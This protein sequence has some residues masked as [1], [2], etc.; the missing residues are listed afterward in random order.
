MKQED[1]SFLKV[2]IEID[3]QALAVERLYSIDWHL[4]V[5]R[6]IGLTVPG[7]ACFLRVSGSWAHLQA[8]RVS[9][10][11]RTV[12][13]KVTKQKGGQRRDGRNQS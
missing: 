9:Q 11:L 2:I 7:Q 10:H 3:T 12:V 5:V 4:W 6:E 13:R 8:M 1:T